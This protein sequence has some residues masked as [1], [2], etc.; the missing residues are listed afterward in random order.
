MLRTRFFTK[1][2]FPSVNFRNK[3]MVIHP[4]SVNRVMID[5]I[6]EHTV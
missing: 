4:H 3:C 6:R 2:L 5:K 1:V